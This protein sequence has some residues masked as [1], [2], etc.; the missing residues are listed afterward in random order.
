MRVVP[1][2]ARGRGR[3]WPALRREAWRIGAVLTPE[4]EGSIDRLIG[5][6]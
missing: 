1:A 3:L 2:G 4:R 6:Q 5:R